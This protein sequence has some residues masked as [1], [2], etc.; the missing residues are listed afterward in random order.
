MLSRSLRVLTQYTSTSSSCL[1]ESITCAS[2][3]SRAAAA[4]LPSSSTYHIR[5]LSDTAP[6]T[7]STPASSSTPGKSGKLPKTRKPAILKPDLHQ[8]HLCS[9]SYDP[10]KPP[11]RQLLPPYAPERAKK[12]NYR[13]LMYAS[14]PLSFHRNSYRRHWKYIMNHAFDAWRRKF[15]KKEANAR[16]RK[17]VQDAIEKHEA[18]EKAW[19]LWCSQHAPQL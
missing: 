8:W 16:F 1:I 3:S 12:K 6:A 17:E 10:A 2:T 15:E 13:A 9:P 19:Q 18:R 7:N 11:P 5:S 14:K 4:V